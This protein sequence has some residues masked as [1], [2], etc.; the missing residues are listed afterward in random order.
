MLR[1]LFE[2][3][4]SSSSSFLVHMIE[5]SRT[6]RPDTQGKYLL[7]DKCVLGLLHVLIDLFLHTRPTFVSEQLATVS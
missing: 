2:I 6:A 7:C 1:Q 5:D 3:E 4:P